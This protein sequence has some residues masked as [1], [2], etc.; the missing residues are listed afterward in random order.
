MLADMCEVFISRQERETVLTTGCG[1]QKIDWPGINTL[2]AATSTKPRSRYIGR[3]SQLKQGIWIKEGQKIV[4]LFCR[5][6]SIEKF[7]QNI[8]DQKQSVSGF[9]MPPK[10]SDKRMILIDPRSPQDQRPH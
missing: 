4:E 9:N 3:T 8:T 10:G 5:T 2:R 6:E 7:L 1:Y